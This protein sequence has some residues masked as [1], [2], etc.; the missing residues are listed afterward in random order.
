MWLTGFL[1]INQNIIQ[2]HYQKMSSLLTTILVIY[3]Y[4]PAVTLDKPKNKRRIWYKR[5]F[6]ICYLLGFSFD[7]M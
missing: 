1:S 5:P 2:I 4:K 3:P 7:D 6:S